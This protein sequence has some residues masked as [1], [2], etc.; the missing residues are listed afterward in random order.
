[1]AKRFLC[2]AKNFNCTYSVHLDLRCTDCFMPYFPKPL[3]K[4]AVK[5][6]IL[7]RQKKAREAAAEAAKV[8]APVASEIKKEESNG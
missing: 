8:T 5:A 2:I 1:M 3:D 7:E 4:E 6:R